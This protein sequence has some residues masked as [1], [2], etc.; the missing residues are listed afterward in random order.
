MQTYPKLLKLLNGFKDLHSKMALGLKSYFR[1]LAALSI[2][3]AY[4]YSSSF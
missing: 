2:F 1:Y 3:M 4:F